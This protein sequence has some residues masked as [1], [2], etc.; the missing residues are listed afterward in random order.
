MEIGCQFPMYEMWIGFSVD[1][2]DTRKCSALVAIPLQPDSYY[3]LEQLEML[4][5]RCQS[6]L[7]LQTVQCC[8]Q[9]PSLSQEK[10]PV[11]AHGAGDKAGHPEE[12][13]KS[14]QG[15]H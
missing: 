12:P 11:A 6:I 3:P 2:I 9:Q 15:K 13:C 8:W 7:T 10:W 14:S 5:Q 4:L 1:I